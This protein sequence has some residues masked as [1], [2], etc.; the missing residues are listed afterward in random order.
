MLGLAVPLARVSSIRRGVAREDVTARLIAI[1]KQ[2]I[3][4]GTLVPGSRLPAERDLAGSFGVRIETQ[5]R[6]DL[7]DDLHVIFSLFE[8]FSPFL[9]EI[10]VRSTAKCGGVDLHSTLL[11]FQSLIQ[12][13]RWDISERY[14][15]WHVL[16]FH[17]CMLYGVWRI[18]EQLKC[19]PKV[20]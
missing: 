3:A 16:T 7:S 4:E 5:I 18:A 11:G 12:Q 19:R 14:F 20:S 17:R 2:L 6:Q 10:F 1:F 9:S 8:I 13:V 15:G